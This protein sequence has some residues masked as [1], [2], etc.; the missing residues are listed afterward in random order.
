MNKRFLAD[1]DDIRS[2]FDIRPPY[3]RHTQEDEDFVPRPYKS[4]SV[5]EARPPRHSEL[6]D[7]PDFNKAICTLTDKMSFNGDVVRF[8]KDYVLYSNSDML[9]LKYIRKNIKS[10]VETDEDGRQY[11]N[12]KL[13]GPIILKDIEGSWS[14]VAK[15]IEKLYPFA[16]E[17]PK[18]HNDSADMTWLMHRMRLAGLSDKDIALTLNNS[19]D[20]ATVF[21]ESGVGI[22][23]DR[24]LQQID[25]SYR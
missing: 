14:P 2:K 19:D 25:K 20:S 3:T 4:D 15:E 9:Y 17:K 8:V 18:M 21:T 7:D 24:L 6:Y 5:I 23:L 1:V 13:Y 12:L 11:I 16:K 22:K 10:S